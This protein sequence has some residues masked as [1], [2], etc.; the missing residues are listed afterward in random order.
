MTYVEGPGLLHVYP[1]L[2]IPEARAAFERVEA[3]L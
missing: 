3:F 1:I 2:P